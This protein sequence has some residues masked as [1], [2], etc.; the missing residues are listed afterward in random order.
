MVEIL[1]ACLYGVVQGLTEFLPVSSSGHLVIAKHYL[2]VEDAGITM[3]V[4]THAA[5]AL[6]VLIYMRRRVASILGAVAGLARGGRAAL[7][8]HG[9]AE[10]RLAVLLVAATVPAV[11]AGLLVRDH[12]E[13]LFSDVG[14]TARMLIVTGVF[15]YL[16]GRLG[17]GEWPF[18]LP[19]ALVVGLAQA[20]A[21]MPGLSRS[22]LTV[23]S[24]LAL[25]I[26]RRR[27]F[28]FALLLSIPVILGA[29][30]FELLGGRLEGSLPLLTAAF[31]AAF[32]SGYLAI[33][34]LFRTVV[35]NRF[36]LFAYYLIPVGIL[37]MIAQ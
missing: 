13:G 18:T 33:S 15:V 27:A 34:L 22:G 19:R 8:E 26:E 20:L 23:G 29:T 1:K 9:R 11:V 24:G 36:Y 25:G 2:G 37:L 14:G 35:K 31:A 30:V 5:T 6:A 32:V 10:V 3:E 17:R 16:T 12:V 7:D 4:L 28:E 21:I